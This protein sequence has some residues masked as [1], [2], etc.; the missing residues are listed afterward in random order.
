M[1]PTRLFLLPAALAGLFTVVNL[2]FAQTWTPTAA[3]TNFWSAIASS[4]D[5]LRFGALARDDW[6]KQPG[7]IYLS[8]NG[9]VSWTAGSAPIAYW[10]CIAFSADGIKLA[11]ATEYLGQGGIYVSTAAHR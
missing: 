6:S 4:T 5:G 3:P 7:A 2:A 8:T 9:G 10:S 1:K 11:A